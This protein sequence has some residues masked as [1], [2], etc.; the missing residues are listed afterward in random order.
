MSKCEL[1]DI[2][3]KK[4]QSKINGAVARNRLKGS[5]IVDLIER[6]DNITKELSGPNGYQ[7]SDFSRIAVVI[8]E[9]LNQLKVNYDQFTV[10]Y[11]ESKLN[12]IQPEGKVNKDNT[13]ERLYDTEAVS[14]LMDAST[15]FLVQAYGSAVKVKNAVITEQNLYLVDSCFV[16]RGSI[17]GETGIVRN[18]SELN[19]N[20]RHYQQHL[21]NQI[22]K[23][24]KTVANET[25][26]TK[27]ELE[28]LENP[29]LYILNGTEYEYTG[30][31][32]KLNN[33]INTFISPIQF[34]PEYL[35]RLQEQSLNS[36]NT[37]ESQN[38]TTILNAF[39]A[40]VFLKHFDTYVYLTLGK[41]VQIRDFGSKT[42]KDKYQI[43]EKTNEMAR[44]WRE[45]DEIFVEDELDNITKLLISTTKLY[46]WQGK[47]PIQG[48]FIET[49][50]FYYIIA[51]IKQL[52]SD[53]RTNSIV[54]NDEFIDNNEILWNSLSEST[55]RVIYNKSFSRVINQIR[56]NP[57]R[58]LHAVFEL[59][60]NQK[61]YDKGTTSF[62]S[63]NNW[64][65]EDKQKLY[66]I[67]KGI[68]NLNDDSS[69]RSI[70][71][72]NPEIDY[73]GFIC[74]VSDSIFKNDF[75]QY[76][77]DSNGKIETRKL[78]DLTLF[79][80][81]QRFKQNITEKNNKN[82]GN[83]N[84]RINKYNIKSNSNELE[85]FKEITF[86]IPKTGIIV[87]VNANSGTVILNKDGKELT[88]FT[89]LLENKQVFD[90]L[91][92]VLPLDLNAEFIK[93][94]KDVT[95]GVEK[96]LLSLASR[97]MLNQYVQNVVF[98]GLTKIEI[99]D[100]IN[101]IYNPEQKISYN[102][103]FKQINLFSAIDNPFITNITL[104]K[105]IVMKLT[106]SAQIKDSN[107]ASQSAQSLSR[108]IGSVI[109]QR[110]LIELKEGS[111]TKDLSLIKLG[112][113]FEGHFTTS[114][115]Y[116]QGQVGRKS[117][118]FSISELAYS[119][120]LL[121]FVRAFADTNMNSD[122]MISRGHALFLASVNSDKTTIGQ[123]M[124]NLNTLCPQFNK[125]F[126]DLN[127]EELE[128]LIAT[129]FGQYYGNMYDAIESD[130]S[131]LTRFLNNELGF[132]NIPNLGKDYLNNFVEFNKWCDQN[133]S[134]LN[135]LGKDPISFIKQA[136][137][138]YNQKY[139]LNPI[140]LI[141]QVH[142][143]ESK[144]T[145]PSGKKVNGFVNNDTLIN[146]LARFNPNH[147]WKKD[148][149]WDWRKYQNSRQFWDIKKGEVVTSLIESGFEVNLLNQNIENQYLLNNFKD[150]VSPSKKMIIA[151]IKI[152]GNDYSITSKTDLR[153]I[154]IKTGLSEKDII[155]T[156]VFQGTLQLHPKLEQ[157][158]YLDYLFTQ[159][160]MFTT[161]GSHV[162]HKGKGSNA[163][164]KEASRYL[165]QH[166]RNVSMTAQ[167]HQ[168]MLNTLNGIN[169]YYNIACIKDI[170]II[171]QL[172]MSLENTITPYDG[173][174]IVNPFSV[175][176]EN[177]SL[178][179]AKAGI[180]KKQFVH[181]KNGRVGTGGIIKT[182]GFGMT[183]DWMRNS[184]L[185]QGLMQQMT[186]RKWIDENGNPMFNIDI[187]QSWNGNTIIYDNL[188]FKGIDGKFYKIKQIK[189]LGNNKYQ[190]VITEVTIDGEEILKENQFVTEENQK[191]YI[192]DSNYR[193]WQFFGGARSMELIDSKKLQFSESSIK[194][195][196]KAIN[197]I[198]DRRFN[199]LE[200]RQYKTDEVE[201]QDELWQP[202]KMS[203]I[204]Y[205]VTE[206][207]IKQGGANIN[208][209]SKFGE[210]KD[211]NLNGEL[212]E[213]YILDFQRILMY[214]AGIQLD[215]E[216]HA[217]G[218]E[219]SLP[220]QI[221]SAC[222]SRGYSFNQAKQL[223]K[224]LRRATELGIK[225]Q[226]DA[227]KD[228]VQYPGERTIKQLTEETFKIIIDNLSK[229]STTTSFAQIIAKG[230]VE[231]MASNPNFS[232]YKDANFPLSD[233]TIFRKA[234]STVSSFLT[235]QAIR[236][237][238]PGLLS[239]LVP[240]Y[241]IFK[242]YGGRKY[243]SF[244]N[245]EVELQQLQNEQIPVYDSD[246]N[247][248]HGDTVFKGLNIIYVAPNSLI[249]NKDGKPVAIRNTHDGNIYVDE[250]LMQQKFQEKAWQNTRGSKPLNVDFNTYEDW[251]KFA[252]THE[253]MYNKFAIKEGESSF[254][255]ETRI[256]ESALKAINVGVA[257]IELG[258][259]YTITR[260]VE[261]EE[262][263]HDGEILLMPVPVTYDEF[264]DTP[265][266][267]KRLR[268]EVNSGD[269]LE[270]VEN[271]KVGRDLGAYNAKFTT[272]EGERFSLWEIDSI[273][274]A[275]EF[276]TIDE[277]DYPLWVSYKKTEGLSEIISFK[278]F[279]TLINYIY[280][281]PNISFTE[282]NF[283]ELWNTIFE[284]NPTMNFSQMKNGYEQW[285]LNKD[286]PLKR[287]YKQFK[288]YIN[289]AVQNDLKNLSRLT[290]DPL[291]QFDQLVQRYQNGEIDFKRIDNFV[292]LTLFTKEQYT[293]EQ[294]PEIRSK[295]E[296][297]TYVKIDGKL[298]KIDRS[299]IEIIP[300]EIIMPKTFKDEFGFDTYTDLNEVESDPDW[301]I[302]Q[303]IKNQETIPDTQ[304][305]VALK[306]SNG[307]HLYII[308][309]K[310]LK[311]PGLTKLESEILT[312]NENG[313]IIR[314]DETGKM[315]YEIL[316]GTEIY[317]D[318]KGNEVIVVSDTETKSSIDIINSYVG[319]LK[320]GTIEFS[321]NLINTDSKYLL[322]LVTKLELNN[323]VGNYISRKIVPEETV[324]ENT[325]IK[326][327]R[328]LQS[329][330]VTIDNYKELLDEDHHIIKEGRAKHTSFLKSLDI[331][332]ARIPSQSKQ[333]YM[334]MKVVAYDN[335]DIN[336]AHVSVYQ[337]LLQGSKK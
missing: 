56:R 67:A 63:R 269:I 305:D 170:K 229:S 265:A 32:E 247:W 166:K 65:H 16:D 282:E 5:G 141:D 218:S 116:K 252:L 57:R 214:E 123:I 190:R 231:S 220:T 88:T 4:I 75:I 337:I 104:A 19:I 299:S 44:T 103:Q 145:L 13:T 266:Q 275:H 175:Y 180:T 191:E 48:R 133:P 280:N 95:S 209:N 335:P 250:T 132:G 176:L 14:K 52:G 15:D 150:W 72:N 136:T 290:E 253:Y 142:I 322:D 219:L 153:I 167:K 314:V 204:Q 296:R 332:A 331:V 114:E 238:I 230:I 309:S 124:I 59:I 47:D 161:V 69:I 183:N 11:F 192:I 90:F 134:L 91:T 117:T 206:G 208:S 86:S 215:K 27:Q 292:N 149:T 110:D 53:F 228:Y 312:V 289:I 328:K 221:V 239:V 213:E 160:W 225:T 256:N 107:Q 241:G 217:T 87:E 298:H 311:G 306:N 109:S 193:L 272:S 257:D 25:T 293:P 137:L 115:V 96:S 98:S 286:L 157:H 274:L 244:D 273:N 78:I 326:H 307:K 232:F 255:Y 182:A 143:T 140:E 148:N 205:L 68:F 64:T 246:L 174:T 321:N 237:K 99:L 92:D 22:V 324:D 26:A 81:K 62:F 45:N 163:T 288:R 113:L 8:K 33:L 197:S 102:N 212:K 108:L 317:T 3:I 258:R 84:D 318:G 268:K 261:S 71:G 101:T 97:I 278:Q 233:N 196:V 7:Q 320:F 234:L 162:G 271:V 169:E 264:I 200:N 181:F 245:P 128:Q 100:S 41:S 50:D 301:F 43:S 164:E 66:S 211:V 42:G 120:F 202:L 20:I 76:Y 283:I 262:I 159:E 222:A 254:D 55:K 85:S 277:T 329:K 35:R 319:N 194:N 111:A 24:L 144:V 2:E 36:T 242:L 51:K 154:G 279:K 58:N 210:L 60:S 49:Q 83:Y 94:L 151:K 155:S 23:Y 249:S 302:K 291:I 61:F 226:L 334:S 146:I 172:L 125:A 186:D 198:G 147:L 248:E 122:S 30:I 294:L 156:A 224:A 313:R 325:V 135:I 39:N 70:V 105:A 300:Y 139:L 37:S 251:V 10:N 315:I 323:R 127:S 260:I 201:S 281:N 316:T 235:K 138:R 18:N 80:I 179:G 285:S 308:D 267:L 119:N 34:T 54:F 216:H 9:K 152:N 203:D 189:P 199:S 31:L 184:P 310:H 77:I 297:L 236:I 330:E 295:I 73:F 188:Y 270:I 165:A 243:E 303:Y 6:L 263:G 121:N 336:T 82:I 118:K 21:L 240:S 168:F 12:F 28:L 1:N 106:T 178:G 46:E 112:G 130:F 38:A 40:N 327:L 187:T 195:V 284:E 259:T 29:Q 287:T 74:Q 177:Y 223:Y 171:K 207:A 129:E 17:S 126:K 79:N 304:F 185:L 227:V 333:S 93:S 131:E 89:G 173:A 276:S 158:N